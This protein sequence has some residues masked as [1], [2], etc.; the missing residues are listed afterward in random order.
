[1]ETLAASVCRDGDIVIISLA[2]GD[3][4]TVKKIAAAVVRSL[5][6]RTIR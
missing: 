4:T 6:K 5:E 1:M 3:E 2:M